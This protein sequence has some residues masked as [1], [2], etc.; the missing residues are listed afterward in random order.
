[1]PESGIKHVF[2]WVAALHLGIATS[3]LF[4]LLRAFGLRRGACL[5]GAGSWSLSAPV[6]CWLSLPSFLAVGCWLPWLLLLVRVAAFSH[7]GTRTGRLAALGVGGIAGTAI[8]G[9]HLQIVLYTLLTVGAYTAW[10]LIPALRMKAAKPLNTLGAVA[11]A[12]LLAG[13]LSAP[14][15]LPTLELSRISHRVVTKRTPELYAA[16]VGSALPV[17]ALITFAVPDFYGHPNAGL[18]WNNSNVRNPAT[19]ASGNNY[20]E[21]A[22]YVG[23]LPLLLAVFALTVTPFRGEKAFFAVLALLAILIATGSPLNLLLYYV[24]PGYASLSN[25]GRV[26]IVF[27]L[28]VSVLAAFGANALLSADVPDASKR[29]GAVIAVAVV[30]LLGAVGVSLGMGWATQAVAQIPF[31]DLVT[32]AT[33]GLMLAGVWFAAAVGLLFAAP[34]FAK[35]APVFLGLLLAVTALDLGTW[36]YNYNPT[37]KPER[38]YPVTPGIT[39]LQTN[40]SDARIAVINR[41]WTLGQTAPR[42]AVLPPNALTVYRLHDIGGYDSLFPK[43]AKDQVTNAGSDDASPPANGNMVFVKSVQTAL[44][45][46]AEYIVLAGDSPPLETGLAEVFTGSDLR[47]LRGVEAV[48]N[49]SP[50]QVPPFPASLRVGLWLAA[51]AGFL[52]IAGSLTLL[53]R[54]G[55][56]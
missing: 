48:T 23:I 50:A 32:Q 51:V 37:A 15:V 9:G 56:G 25:P 20:A 26:L 19:G 38:V 3:G 6:I 14:Q 24:V 11:L 30:L 22:V 27:A 45:L 16:S 31:A 46:G 2:G 49:P 1:M 36:G 54:R 28:A 13:S 39:W 42:F 52:L 29:R 5:V 55:G 10:C 35:N 34:R 4:V 18:H 40:A 47:I 7:T 17:R 53:L 44:N 21:W 8:L 12:A 43:A 41:D 33:P